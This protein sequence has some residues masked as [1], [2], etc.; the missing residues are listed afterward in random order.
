MSR[1]WTEG[2]GEVGDASDFVMTPP[3]A[4]RLMNAIWLLAGGA[5][6][7]VLVAW[8]A[9]YA[10]PLRFVEISLPTSQE[11]DRSGKEGPFGFQAHVKTRWRGLGVF[12]DRLFLD[13]GSESPFAANRLIEEVATLTDVERIELADRYMRR[14]AHL[15]S[16]AL[17]RCGW[18]LHCLS[19][20]QWTWPPSAGA[21]S[22]QVQRVVKSGQHG[23][24]PWPTCYQNAIGA[25]GSVQSTGYG[26][27]LPRTFPLYPLWAGLALD[28]LCYAVLILTI[29][30]AW[31]G[32]IRFKRI[33]RGQ[34]PRCAYQIVAA[35][36]TSCSECGWV[37]SGRF[38]SCG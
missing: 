27:A 5:L 35:G 26:E 17:V 37:N 34:C 32:A 9:A 22:A 38:P 36:F 30:L 12:E 4:K 10:S 15:H 28:S 29:R 2:V 6:V 1:V 7:S 21:S 31:I 25:P 3:L 33:A 11:R 14:I 13:H 8:I 20:E 18:P 24:V 23:A 19:G 16:W